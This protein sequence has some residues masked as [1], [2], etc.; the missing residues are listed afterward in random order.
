MCFGLDRSG[1]G[2]VVNCSRISS[3]N[4]NGFGS[5]VDG[6][7]HESLSNGKL[8]WDVNVNGSGGRLVINDRIFLNSL[9]I[10]WSF[11][12]FPSNDR[13][14]YDSL[15]DNRLTDDSLSNNWLTNNFSSYNRFA[16][17]SLSMS[18]YWFTI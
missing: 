2:R 1:D 7:L 6:W 15:S 11:Y 3:V 13:G 5:G 10:N 8:S 12:N 14:L 18:N 9:S 4:L 17:N 16:F